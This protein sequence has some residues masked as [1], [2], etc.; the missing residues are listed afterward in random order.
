MNPPP[1]ADDLDAALYRGSEKLDT[2]LADRFAFVL[3]TPCWKSLVDAD[4]DAVISSSDGPVPAEVAVEIRDLVA[5]AEARIAEVQG[6]HGA[7][8]VDYVRTV[9]GLL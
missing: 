8:L 3:E 2:A 5:K 4:R 6:R 1:P 7:A 9:V